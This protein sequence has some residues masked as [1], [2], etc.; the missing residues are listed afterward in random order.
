MPLSHDQRMFVQERITAAYAARDGDKVMR[1]ANEYAEKWPGW[2]ADYYRG[3]GFELLGWKTSAVGAFLLARKE[4]AAA[5]AGALHPRIE[6]RIS[7]LLRV[8]KTDAGKSSNALGTNRRAVRKPARAQNSSATAESPNG[9]AGRKAP[10]VNGRRDPRGRE[11]QQTSVRQSARRGCIR[12]LV[13]PVPCLTVFR[14]TTG[15]IATE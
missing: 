12:E 3:A 9:D 5:K 2:R 6:A 14:S 8:G 13:L 15:S 7:A 4:Y 1:L 11:F 10:S